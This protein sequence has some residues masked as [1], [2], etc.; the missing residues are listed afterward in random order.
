VVW[1]VEREAQLHWFEIFE[2]FRGRGLGY[3]LMGELLNRLRKEKVEKVTLEVSEKNIPTLRVYEK[4]GFKRVGMR[5]N[6]YP[7]GSNAILME[8]TL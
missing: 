6:H 1:F 3:T 5:K 8:L 4:S 2:P 7:D